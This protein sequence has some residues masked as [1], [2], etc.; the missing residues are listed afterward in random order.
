M[1]THNLF[2][3][4]NIILEAEDDL[5]PG[6][7]ADAFDNKI[8]EVDQDDHDELFKEFQKLKNRATV[9]FRLSHKITEFLMRNYAMIY[10]APQ[11]DRLVYYKDFDWFYKYEKDQP[12]LASYSISKTSPLFDDIERYIRDINKYKLRYRYHQDA[13]DKVRE[14]M[15]S[16][17]EK[18]PQ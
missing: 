13:A 10:D 1:K 7:G 15:H 2:Y 16:L 14:R 6:I 12:T 11:S 4:A 18:K 9:F 3:H 5:F 8:K 17:P